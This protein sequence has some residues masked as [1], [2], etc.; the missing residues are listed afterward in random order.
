MNPF[1]E[2]TISNT[3]SLVDDNKIEI[4]KD[5]VKGKNVT[6]MTGWNIDS[7]DLKSHLKNFKKTRGCNGSL[8]KKDNTVIF[9]LQGDKIDDLKDYLIDNEVDENKIRVKG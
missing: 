9:Q 3:S 7:D 6:Y 2:E 8:K 1:E 4:W 5:K